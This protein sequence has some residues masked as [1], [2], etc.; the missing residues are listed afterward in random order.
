M[1]AAFIKSAEGLKNISE[2]TNELLPRFS[3]D[4]QPTTNSLE[5]AN[6]PIKNECDFTKV[7]ESKVNQIELNRE[8]GAQREN[9]AYNDLVKEYPESEGH[10]L[11]E[12]V[13]LRNE[14][15][16]IVKDI[17]SGEGRRVDFM[18]E[19]DNQ[20]IKSI[21][22]TSEIAPKDIQLAKEGRIRENGGNYIQDHETGVLIR[23]PSNINTEVRRYI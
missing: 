10:K 4:I 2:K 19:K 6:L 20:I 7:K 21:E 13:F 17:E 9:I 16:S 3:K 12:E 1:L 18:V 14:L 22:V 15:G 8:N 23:I 11:H 5:K